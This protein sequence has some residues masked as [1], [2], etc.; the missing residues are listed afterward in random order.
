MEK[1][2]KSKK[3]IIRFLISNAKIEVIDFSI[4]I[5]TE[6]VC[7]H[8][9]ALYLADEENYGKDQLPKFLDWLMEN[10]NEDEPGRLRRLIGKGILNE[11]KEMNDETFDIAILGLLLD[12][13]RNLTLR[14]QAG[15]EESEGHKSFHMIR[16]GESELLF[17]NKVLET[18]EEVRK[19]DGNTG[20]K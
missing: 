1:N 13:I 15:S 12:D 4:A 2:E 5:I 11:M 20:D 17:M 16:S 10:A 7:G 19:A 8:A 9:K 14:S 18:I 6:V 3:D